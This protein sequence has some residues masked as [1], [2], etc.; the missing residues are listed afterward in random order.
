MHERL[1]K[2]QASCL[3]SFE[4]LRCS[5]RLRVAQKSAAL[6]TDVT[7]IDGRA[8]SALFFDGAGAPVSLFPLPQRGSGA[9]GGAMRAVVALWTA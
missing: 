7:T 3:L 5:S 4:A 6:R 9:P 2:F 1:I 8:S